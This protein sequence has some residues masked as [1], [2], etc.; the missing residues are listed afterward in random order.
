MMTL[1][2]AKKALE[3]SEKKAAELEVAVSTAVVDD[4]GDL[5]AFSR[6][7]LTHRH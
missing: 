2:K 7:Q 4:Y 1:Q 6:K 5:I 3:A